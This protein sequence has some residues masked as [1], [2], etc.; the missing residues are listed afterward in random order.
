MVI[1]L[2][3]PLNV[4]KEVGEDIWIVD[5]DIIRMDIKVGSIPFSTRMT[6]IRLD[7]GSLFIHSPIQPNT[8]LI[9]EIRKLGEVKHLVSSNMLHY[10]YI[11]DWQKLFP[12]AIAWASPG[13][14]ERAKSQQFAIEFDRDLTNEAPKEWE[15]EIQQEIFKGSRL[16]E[17]VVFFHKKSKTLILTDLI[18]NFEPDKTE[19]KFYKL[20]YKLGGI[21]SPDG[22]TPRDLRATFIGNKEIARAS[23][24]RILSWEPEKIIIAHGKWFEKDG[25]K[26]LK[27]AFR[28][29][30]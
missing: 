3:R 17:E 23:F 30:T 15:Q 5:G 28:W 7:D 13:V 29:L 27:R 4:L 12:N 9:A 2:Y 16:L 1:P 24:K 20:L 14:R 11:P 21:A 22:Q 25:V 8:E 10:A 6:I 26:E 18:E 19:S